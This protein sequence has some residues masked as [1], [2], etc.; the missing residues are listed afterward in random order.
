MPGGRQHVARVAARSGRWAAWW[1][2]VATVARRRGLPQN[3]PPPEEVN[4]SN[5]CTRELCATNDAKKTQCESFLATCLAASEN[6]ADR[7]EC[8]AGALLICQQV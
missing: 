4:E 3:E 1:Y 8:V 7:E 6:D 5:V 2:S